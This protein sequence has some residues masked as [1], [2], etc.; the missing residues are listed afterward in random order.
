LA[1]RGLR[2]IAVATRMLGK[3]ARARVDFNGLDA[4]RLERDL[5]LLGLIGL[6][7]PPRPGAAAALKA[8]RAQGIKVAMITGDHP[9]TARAIAA[10]V[11]LLGAEELVV[12]GH[13][14]PDD[15]VALGALLDRDGVVVSRVT[16]ED[17]LRIA[18]AL[19]A[20]GH[21]VAMTGDGLN[22]GP[23]LQAADIGVA[24]GRSGTDVAREASDLVL[25]DDDFATIVAAVTQGRATYANIRRF[26]TY[27][28]TDNV[29]EL[30][31]FAVWALSGGLFP[32]ALGVL[33][34][35]SLDVLT[36]QI[37]ALALGIEEPGDDVPKH[38]P[39]GERLL[40][41]SM[42]I[43]VFGVLGPVEALVEMAAFITVLWADGWRPGGQ[44]PAVETLLAASGAAFA[45][46]VIGQAAN[47]FACRDTTRWPGAL[48]W[49]TNRLLLIGIGVEL[50]LLGLLLFVPPLAALLG[51][52]PPTA[53]GWLV[54]ALAA[55]SVL[56]ADLVHKQLTARPDLR[57]TNELE[58]DTT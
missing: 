31:P 22:D 5:D 56:L 15:E 6:E 28:L 42:L 27:H 39:R 53:L 58:G 8:C 35:L 47:A 9:G 14:L 10:E 33:Q 43:R 11:G 52:A 12:E 37:P 51:Q 46:V 18:K 26:L 2:V 45:A 29:A 38:P 48:G 13:E 20:R 16:P 25:L 40:D 17:K 7:D 34:V 32:L 50:V 4:D 1:H 49:T 19:R 24:M 54:A 3:E 23:A 57:A 30:T 55:P 36:D 44:L 41:R 21:V